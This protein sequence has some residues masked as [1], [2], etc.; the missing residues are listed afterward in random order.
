GGSCRIDS[1]CG[2]TLRATLRVVV[3]L[4]DARTST[5]IR[6]FHSRPLRASASAVQK[7]KCFCLILHDSVNSVGKKIKSGLGGA[8]TKKAPKGAFL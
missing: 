6:L 1:A 5:V 2:L 4:R 8:E 7:H 3:S